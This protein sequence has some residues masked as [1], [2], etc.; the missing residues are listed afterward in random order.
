MASGQG[1]FCVGADGTTPKPLEMLPME[2]PEP[3]RALSPG[4]C[5]SSGF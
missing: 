2:T 3:V 4:F 5:P 1:M